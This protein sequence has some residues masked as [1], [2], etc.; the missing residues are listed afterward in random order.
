MRSSID[1]RK[2][3]GRANERCM[4]PINRSMKICEAKISG[5]FILQ[6]VVEAARAANVNIC[7]NSVGWLEYDRRSH[8]FWTLR[9][10]TIDQISSNHSLCGFTLSFSLR[11]CVRGMEKCGERFI[12]I[13]QKRRQLRQRQR[14]QQTKTHTHNEQISVGWKVIW[15]CSLSISLALSLS[16]SSRST[17]T[18][19]KTN[20]M[21]KN[22]FVLAKHSS[23]RRKFRNVFFFWF[24][25]FSSLLRANFMWWTNFNG[26]FFL[27]RFDY[28]DFVFLSLCVH[29]VLIC[30][31]KAF[32][33]SPGLVSI[34]HP[35]MFTFS[36]DLLKGS[37]RQR[38]TAAR[39]H[40]TTACI[41]CKV[42][43]FIFVV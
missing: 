38:M 22:G 18:T 2:K 15:I 32:A 43:L 3:S 27:T 29:A 28:Y 4:S 30:M 37:H 9:M 12:N 14:K 34:C 20:G 1:E 13:Q 35:L 25:S 16:L 23:A 26:A 8:F 39:N 19:S 11:V 40:T 6:F 5:F 21:N 33:S 17:T 10:S 36:L 41:I 24:A 42:F 7:T 31:E